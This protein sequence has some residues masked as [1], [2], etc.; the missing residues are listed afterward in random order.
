M[1][2]LT[3]MSTS[4]VE[5]VSGKGYRFI[6]EVDAVQQAPRSVASRA[7]TLAVLPFENL[8]GTPEHDYI[9][10]GFTEE[11]T[12]ALGQID[13]E[14]LSVIGRTS[15]MGYKRTT[16]SLAEIGRKLGA[17]Y[18]IE[19]STPSRQARHRRSPC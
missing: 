4:F 16:K 3:P 9:A 10:D 12:T 6:A 7:V 1:A 13:P 17:T 5:T 19:G 8:G 15:V 14:H 18:V 2:V 11:A